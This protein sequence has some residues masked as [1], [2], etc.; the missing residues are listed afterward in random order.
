MSPCTG[1][2]K[3]CI[4]GMGAVVAGEAVALVLGTRTFGAR[5]NPWNTRKN[6]ALLGLDLV[7]GTVL[8]WL[9]LAVGE[10]S[11]TPALYVVVTLEAV[12]DCASAP[13]P[14]GRWPCRKGR[15][16]AIVPVGLSRCA[17]AARRC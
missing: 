3:W 7:T 15:S 9:A 17:V 11:R 13:V 1:W 14:D 6:R 12:G 2:L 16:C 8:L 5:P 4:A 10:H